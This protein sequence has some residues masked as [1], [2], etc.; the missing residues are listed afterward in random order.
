MDSIRTSNKVENYKMDSIEQ[1]KVE[2]YK[3]DSIEHRI[4]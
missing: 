1:N 3:M 4:R 2:N